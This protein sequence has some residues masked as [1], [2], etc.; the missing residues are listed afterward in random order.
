MFEIGDVVV[1]KYGN[2]KFLVTNI[3]GLFDVGAISI[4]SKH[5]AP[6]QKF[7]L[8][9][10]SLKKIGHVGFESILNQIR[11]MEV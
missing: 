10:S 7:T 3:D 6:F 9:E 5:Y 2:D 4:D 11:E 8:M 1:T